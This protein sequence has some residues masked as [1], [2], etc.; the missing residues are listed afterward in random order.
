MPE[1]IFDRTEQD[2]A[3]K[4]EKGTYNI[5]DLNRVEENVRSLST[6]MQALPGLLQGYAEEKEVAWDSSFSVPYGLEDAQVETKTDWGIT[7]IPEIQDMERYLGNIKKQCTLLGLPVAGL[8]ATMEFLNWEG[9]N[10]IERYLSRA[11]DAFAALEQER[12]SRID[13]AAASWIY[14]GELA[15]GEI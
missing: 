1:F 7:D 15:A 9:A 11:Y 2:A 6:D 3:Q 10:R 8:P 13:H 12:K 5:A 14:A 4:N